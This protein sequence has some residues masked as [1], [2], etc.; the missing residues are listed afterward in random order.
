MGRSVV[1]GA[2][3]ALLVLAALASGQPAAAQ[4]IPAGTDFWVTRPDGATQFNFPPG[5]VE[6]LCGAAAGP[7]I[8]VVLVGVPAPGADWDSAVARLSDAVFD[9]SGVAETKVRF[10]SLSMRSAAATPTPCGPL[11]WQAR[12]ANVAQPV[13]SMKIVRNSPGG[14][15]FFAELALRVEMQANHAGSHRFVGRLF[16]DVKLPDPA[17]GTPWSFGPA[18]GFRPGMTEHDDCID[19]LRDKLGTFPPDSAHAYF[20]SDLIAQGKCSREN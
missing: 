13:T 11:N 16:Y 5:D 19:V 12:L 9:S 15:T 1:R 17:A 7:P 20:I 14:G 4:V 3:L 6:A 10:A 2:V 8:T 18:G